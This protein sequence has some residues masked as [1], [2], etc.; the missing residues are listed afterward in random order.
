MLNFNNKKRLKIV[1][2]RLKATSYYST[3]VINF[4]ITRIPPISLNYPV[5]SK[6]NLIAPNRKRKTNSFDGIIKA[7][8]VAGRKVFKDIIPLKFLM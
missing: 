1:H 3:G 7:N 5:R 2:I 8:S 4:I 6:M